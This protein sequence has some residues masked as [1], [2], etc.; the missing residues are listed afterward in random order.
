MSIWVV[1]GLLL[2]GS[3]WQVGSGK[4]ILV[5][6][7][8]WLPGDRPYIIRS[9]RVNEVNFVTDLIDEHSGKCKESVVNII[10]NDQ[11]AR[12]ILSTPLVQYGLLDML[13]WCLK[14]SGEYTMR[15]GYQLLLR[16]FPI[17]KND[18][19]RDI[20]ESLFEWLQQL[21]TRNS[22]QQ[23]L[24]I[25]TIWALWLSR[26]KLLH[27]G[28]RQSNSELCTF[29]MRYIKELEILED[30]YP[31]SVTK[32]TKRWLPPKDRRV[33]V[34]FDR[35]CYSDLKASSSGIIIG[36]NKGLIMGTTCS[37]ER[38]ILFVEVTKALAS[39]SCS[40]RLICPRDWV[41][42]SRG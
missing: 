25:I 35:R 4:S 7:I 28:K 29:L 8:A 9:P 17:I 26:N 6:D 32:E 11:E 39:G 14:K 23:V 24:I 2:K 3:S 34:N 10:V 40:G 20:E 16:G 1:K 12:R 31:R 22:Q 27:E 5:W 36:D 13:R 37:W 41:S 33:K 42:K 38:N 15:N 21:F 30:S 18:S 19:Y